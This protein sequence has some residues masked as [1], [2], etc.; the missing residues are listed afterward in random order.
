MNAPAKHLSDHDYIESLL[1]SAVTDLL[2]GDDVET[3]ERTYSKEDVM[4]RIYDNKDD[5]KDD[6][7]ELEGALFSLQTADK[8]GYEFLV[9]KIKKLIGRAASELVDSIKLELIAFDEDKQAEAKAQSL[10]SDMEFIG[11]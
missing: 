2:N 7:E 3:L 1:S 6:S 10:L 4:L 5:N 9:S 8:A 11:E